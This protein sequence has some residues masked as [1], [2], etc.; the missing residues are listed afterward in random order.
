MSVWKAVSRSR[1]PALRVALEAVALDR[2]RLVD[3]GVDEVGMPIVEVGADRVE[4][5]VHQGLD[6]RVRAEFSHGGRLRREQP[7]RHAVD[8]VLHVPCRRR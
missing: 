6:E 5:G 3:D 8:R 1:S 4:V 7:A 2:L